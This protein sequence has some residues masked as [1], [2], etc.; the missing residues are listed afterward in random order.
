VVRLEEL[1]ARLVRLEEYLEALKCEVG[2]L[3][4]LVKQQLDGLPVEIKGEPASAVSGAGKRFALPGE[5][6]DNLARLYQEGY[7]IC[8]VHF[9][10]LRGAGECLFCMAL[11]KGK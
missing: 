4:L 10:D 9:G 8:H 2:Q 11:L 7:H 6:Y 3:R 1:E 5:G